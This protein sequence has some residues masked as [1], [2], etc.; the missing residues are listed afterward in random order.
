MGRDHEGKHKWLGTQVAYNLTRSEAG[1]VHF[2][3]NP[4]P[5]QA[6]SKGLLMRYMGWTRV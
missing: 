5:D 1:G 3:F 2:M 4:L 6:T